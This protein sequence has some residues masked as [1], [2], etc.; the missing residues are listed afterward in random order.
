MSEELTPPVVPAD[1]Y[2]EDYFRTKCAGSE[3]WSA[4]G[5]SEVAGIYPGCLDKAGFRPGE[6]VVDIGT[7]RGDMLAAAVRKG[8]A[9][10]I[11]V[12]YAEAA[13]RLAELTIAVQGIG[14]RAQVLHVDARRIPLD[15][16]ICDLVTLVDVVEHLAPEELDHTLAE[17]F[18]LLKP[19]GRVLVHTMPSR[20][21]YA[22]TYRLQR[23]LRPGRARSWPRDPRNDYE[24]LMHVNEQT[25]SSLG[26][27]LRGAGF[28]PAAATVGLWIYTDFVPEE[29][30]KRLYHW[31]ARVPLVNRLGI[32][33]LWGHGTKPV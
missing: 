27:A 26:K 15:D 32:G 25:V 5:G 30:A 7:G 24:R 18:R 22:V 6:V 2:D 33:D 21:I 31:L 17:A 1:A 10:A 14:D 28:R 16:E 9:R 3:E 20:T 19:G 29:R 4:S 8:A 11:G 13:V 12:E 23:I